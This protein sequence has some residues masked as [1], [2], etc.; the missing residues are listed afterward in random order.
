[1]DTSGAVTSKRTAPQPH[2]PCSGSKRCEAIGSAACARARRMST[3]APAVDP[4]QRA[5]HVAQPIDVAAYACGRVVVEEC[6]SDPHDRVTES[7]RVDGRLIFA[8]VD[9]RNYQRGD[10]LDDPRLDL[11]S[12]R[13][14]HTQRRLAL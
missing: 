1:A 3:R 14:D 8:R 2:P 12:A 5:L 4:E 7:R 6:L 13:G 10:Q 9:F 11:R